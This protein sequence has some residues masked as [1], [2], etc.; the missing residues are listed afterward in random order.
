MRKLNFF[1][2]NADKDLN[3]LIKG[4]QM[5]Q[6]ARRYLQVLKGTEVLGFWEQA[7]EQR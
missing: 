7:V 4:W 1:A 5:Q 6:R 2:P 3:V